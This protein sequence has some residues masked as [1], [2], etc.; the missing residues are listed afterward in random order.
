MPTQS[1]AKL[2]MV[3]YLS[4]ASMSLKKDFSCPL[5]QI[6]THE[7]RDFSYLG[8]RESELGAKR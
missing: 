2:G 7:H 4:A 1:A 6:S 5:L 3:V 8:S